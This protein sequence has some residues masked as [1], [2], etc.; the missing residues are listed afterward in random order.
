MHALL[1][2]LTACDA[3]PPPASRPPVAEH[4]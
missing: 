3:E 4:A 1:W 2:M